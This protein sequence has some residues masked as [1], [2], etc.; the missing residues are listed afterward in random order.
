MDSF[1]TFINQHR[2]D[3]NSSPCLLT[4]SGGVDSVVMLHLFQK[5]G[6]PV[7]VAHCNFGLR[8]EESEGDEQFVKALAEAYHLPFYSKRF[9]T[10]SFAREKHISTQMAARDLRYAWFEELRLT[11]NYTYIATAHHAS[12]SLE[13]TLLN[14]VRGTGLSGLHGIAGINNHL[15][16]PLLLATKEQILTYARE[17]GLQWREDRSNESDDYKRNLLRHKVV[18]VLQQLNPSLEATFIQSSAKLQSADL[19]LKAMLNEW[20]KGVVVEERGQFRISKQE[21]SLENQPAYRLWHVLD[22]FGFSFQQ[23]TQIIAGLSGLSGKRF[24][25]DTHQLLIDREYLI[26]QEKIGDNANTSFLIDKLEGKFNFGSVSLIL[27][28][29]PGDSDLPVSHTAYSAF[30]NADKVKLPVTI[31][32]WQQGDIFQPFGMQGKKKK[33]SD[34]FTDLKMDLFTKQNTL[35]LVNGNQE[36]IWVIGLRLDERYRIEEDTVNVLQ[37]R[38]IVEDR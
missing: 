11:H 6:F 30:I 1:L 27:S 37:I 19:L 7:G 8:G 22:K 38:A 3:L 4:V 5:A 15:M 16:R 9:N 33:L 29:N 35:L 21:L 26:I 23:S 10:K 18:P 34:F 28:N 24:L 25:S 12:D 31:R 20:A 32:R 14:L 2:L 36:I 13:T 17:N